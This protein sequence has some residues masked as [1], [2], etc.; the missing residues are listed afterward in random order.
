LYFLPCTTNTMEEVQEDKTSTTKDVKDVKHDI[1]YY[2]DGV[3]FPIGTKL[4]GYREHTWMRHGAFFVVESYTKGYNMR[5]RKF[6]SNYET[7]HY[8]PADASYK[9]TP[10]E[11][12]LGPLRIAR[13]SQRN[14][15]WQVV[16]GGH[17]YFLMDIYKGDPVLFHTYG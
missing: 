4:V 2:N 11:S 16:A 5:L 15:C 3:V 8:G 1:D 13:Y 17:R 9:I 6:A 10:D 7:L 12:N 14:G